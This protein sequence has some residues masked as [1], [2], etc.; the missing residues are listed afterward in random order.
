MV[1]KREFNPDDVQ[2]LILILYSREEEIVAQICDFTDNEQLVTFKSP[3]SWTIAQFK[4]MI[5]AVTGIPAS[6]QHVSKDW[7]TLEN[8][9]TLAS[10]NIQNGGTLCVETPMPSEDWL[11]RVVP[12]Y[13]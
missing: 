1:R 12:E 9:R 11:P 5:Q 7:E 4:A 13:L 10:C 6:E 8:T 2:G 3:L